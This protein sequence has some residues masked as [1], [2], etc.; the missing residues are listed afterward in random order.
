[1]ARGPRHSHH[2][3]CRRRFGGR[4]TILIALV[5]L[6]WLY[7]ITYYNAPPTHFVSS[8]SSSSATSSETLPKDDGGG[9][10]DDTAPMPASSGSSAA[11]HRE[12]RSKTREKEPLRLQKHTRVYLPPSTALLKHPDNPGRE[13]TQ[14]HRGLLA[15]PAVQLVPT[16]AGADV[17]VATACSK[18]KP[19]LPGNFTQHARLALI[20]WSD[21][22]EKHAAWH[23][24]TRCRAYFKRSWVLRKK[25]MYVRDVKHP[26]HFRPFSYAVMQEY[27]D[28]SAVPPGDTDA[29]N[30][31]SLTTKTTTT[32]TT[33]TQ[34]SPLV[35]VG[36]Y[37]RTDKA[38]RAWALGVVRAFGKKRSDLNVH[39][40]AVSQASRSSFD[41]SYFEAL[42]RTRIVVTH[43]P[44]GWEGD[45]RTWEALASG[46]LVFGD[47]MRT[48]TPHALVDGE[49]V[50]YYDHDT[51]GA[52]LTE[53]LT[54]YLAR[55]A[56]ARAVALRGQQ[57]ALRYHRPVDRVDYILAETRA[58]I[59]TSLYSD[60]L[61][62]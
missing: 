30:D 1:M 17:I 31:M 24:D 48:P 37:L 3:S 42:R 33:T 13:W 41:N 49:H 44:A 7:F 6:V 28:A 50:V 10:D 56:E 26:P 21:K 35:D 16:I 58:I 23:T 54:Y 36:C 43:N 27:I 34:Q 15:H 60:A 57:Q 2:S 61:A 46:A 62:E 53:R 4:G 25:G 29:R 12:E 20:D 40:G 51:D 11:E 39:V 59:D 14:L 5:L 47:R 45:S 55:P 52:M 18:W 8:S 22:S 9:D 19:R 32:T 38:G